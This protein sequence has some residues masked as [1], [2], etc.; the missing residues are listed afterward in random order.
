MD[1]FSSW[2]YAYRVTDESFE[3]KVRLIGAAETGW[4][5]ELMAGHHTLGAAASGRVLR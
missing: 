4:Y 5:N 2:W 3:V 1:I